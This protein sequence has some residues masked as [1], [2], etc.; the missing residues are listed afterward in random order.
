MSEVTPTMENLT[1]PYVLQ[2]IDELSW[3][4]DEIE[5]F[6][7]SVDKFVCLLA[8]RDAKNE[9]LTA[10]L[11]DCKESRRLI[12]RLQARVEELE[13]DAETHDAQLTKVARLRLDL[14]SENIRLQARVEALELAAGRVCESWMDGNVDCD[15]DGNMADLIAATEQES[16]DG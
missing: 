9:R 11:A 12:E 10:E 6:E 15:L 2:L 14:E 3:Q 16:D 7:A 4:A 8:E 5:R 1:D 13:A